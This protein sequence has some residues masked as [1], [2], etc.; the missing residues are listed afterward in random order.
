MK[1]QRRIVVLAS[2]VHHE[3]AVCEEKAVR[4]DF[5]RCIDDFLLFFGIELWQVVNEL[6]W[7]CWIRDHESELEAV[8]TDNSSTE[9]VPFNHLQGL[10]GLGPNAE[11]HGQA[12]SLELKEI[13]TQVV[14]YQ[15][16]WGI[17]VKFI[18]DVEIFIVIRHLNKGDVADYVTNLKASEAELCPV[19]LKFAEEA[20][21][22]LRQLLNIFYWRFIRVILLLA[23]LNHIYLYLIR[24]NYID[25]NE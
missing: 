14:F 16:L 15:P 21:S 19:V 2:V 24:N 3:F 12:D 5:P 20:V 6:P 7:V 10:D 25:F 9:V 23:N 4:F 8:F 11:I 13:R 1:S 22:W 18:I 17:F